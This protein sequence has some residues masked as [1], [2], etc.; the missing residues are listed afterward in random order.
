MTATR[1]FAARELARRLSE[2]C[3]TGRVRVESVAPTATGFDAAFGVYPSA[4]SRAAAD[5]GDINESCAADTV[6]VSVTDADLDR[7]VEAANVH[8]AGL[9]WVVGDESAWA[10]LDAAAR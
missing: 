9:A 1:T 8:P 3:P 2:S 6:R 7:A 5:A 4:E 10:T